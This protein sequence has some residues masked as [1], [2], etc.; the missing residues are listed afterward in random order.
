M[1][2]EVTLTRN[3]A[4]RHSKF[5]SVRQ[6]QEQN[7]RNAH[8]YTD[9]QLDLASELTRQVQSQYFN[10]R[11]YKNL[12]KTFIAVK[13]DNASTCY[14]LFIIAKKFGAE[15]VQT[16]GQAVILRVFKK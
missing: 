8:L 13:I 7:A 3:T 1:K 2:T 4:V 16:E 10:K 5:L 6:A 9:Q 15:V 12:R 14:N 11:V